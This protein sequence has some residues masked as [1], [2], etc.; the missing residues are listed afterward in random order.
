MKRNKKKKGEKRK[1]DKK[2][3]K[4]KKNGKRTITKKDGKKKKYVRERKDRK[5]GV[6]RRSHAHTSM[7]LP[8]ANFPIFQVGTIFFLKRTRNENLP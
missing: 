5:E 4:Q 7:Y 2:K 1:T 6:F 3:Q 8:G